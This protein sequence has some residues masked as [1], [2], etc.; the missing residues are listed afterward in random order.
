MENYEKSDNESS[1]SWSV[2]SENE[3][4]ETPFELP[5]ISHLYKKIGYIYCHDILN[6]KYQGKIAISNNSYEYATIRNDDLEEKNLETFSKELFYLI[7]EDNDVQIISPII[8]LGVEKV[9]LKFKSLINLILKNDSVIYANNHL[10]IVNLS[11]EDIIEYFDLMNGIRINYVSTPKFNRK[12]DIAYEHIERYKKLEKKP[13]YQ[14]FYDFYDTIKDQSFLTTLK[15]NLYIK[16]KEDNWKITQPEIQSF[17]TIK[18]TGKLELS[19]FNIDFNVNIPVIVAENIED[20]SSSLS[21]PSGKEKSKLSEYFKN[22]MVIRHKIG[23]KDIWTATFNINK[24]SFIRD[25]ITYKSPSSFSGA[26]YKSS[27]PDR[28]SSSNG[29]AECEVC[30]DEIKDKWISI[31]TLRQ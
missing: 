31:D 14:K 23:E 29:W 1:E 8:K 18:R 24:N 12:I 27:R 16:S 11:L 22:N 21:S 19:R 5:D 9:L 7:T 13:N 15:Q 26:H 30:I 3:H 4:D 6:G 25:G 10:V 17:L 28:T 20:A 2:A